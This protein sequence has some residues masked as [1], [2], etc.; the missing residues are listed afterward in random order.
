MDLSAIIDHIAGQADEFLDG[1]TGRADARAGISEYITLYYVHL[2]HEDRAK[3]IDGVA[4]VLEKEGF[5][6]VPPPKAAAVVGKRATRR[7]TSNS[8]RADPG[9]RLLRLEL[10]ANS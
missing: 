10:P 7:A 2:S 6:E 9:F 3:V 4:A 8:V 5:F 1:F